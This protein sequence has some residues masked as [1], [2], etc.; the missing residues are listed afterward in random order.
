[1]LSGVGEKVHTTSLEVIHFTPLNCQVLPRLLD[2]L[3]S[4]NCDSKQSVH[5]VFDGHKNKTTPPAVSDTSTEMT[6][7]PDD[8]CS[9]S[10]SI[11]AVSYS[12]SQLVKRSPSSEQISYIIQHLTCQCQRLS[13]IPNLQY[14]RGYLTLLTSFL[15]SIAKSEFMPLFEENISKVSFLFTELFFLSHT[16]NIILSTSRQNVDP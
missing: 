15:Q 11:I 10:K 8:C 7:S 12:L 6:S 16:L 2:S 9:T 13:T 1:M 14:F 4:L 5:L 3:F